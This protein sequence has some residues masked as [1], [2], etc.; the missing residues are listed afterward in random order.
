MKIQTIEKNGI[1]IACVTSS[2]I[3]ISDVSSA[4]DF[5]MSIHH[6]TGSRCI[7]LNKKAIDDNFFRLGT[8]IAGEILQR[9]INYR[10]KMAVYGDFSV[11][12]SKPLKDFIYESNKGKDFFFVET[13]AEA[14]KLL[15]KAVCGSTQE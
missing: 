15:V 5:M 3:V 14:V 7:A 1:R 6:K 13:E 2:K 12:S 11:Y 4:L 10:I 9:F 8:N